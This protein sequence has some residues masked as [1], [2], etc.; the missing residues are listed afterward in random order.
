MVAATVGAIVYGAGQ[1][2]AYA[3]SRDEYD[4]LVAEYRAAT[5]YEVMSTKKAEMNTKY[6]EVQDNQSKLGT[7]IGIVGGVWLF[8]IIDASLLMPRLRSV[9]RDSPAPEIDLGTRNGRLTLSLR[10]EF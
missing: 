5:T 3:T 7:V 1:F 9:S 8:N 6:E 2:G 4:Q 10:I